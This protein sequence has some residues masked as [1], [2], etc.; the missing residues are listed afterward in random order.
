MLHKLKWKILPIL[1]FHLSLMQ[2]Y[3]SD[4]MDPPGKI[5]GGSLN[6]PIRIEVFSNFGCSACREYYLRTI[7]KVLKEYCSVDKVCVIYHDYPFKSH[8]YDREAA[9][10]AE[11][12]FRINRETMLEV[13]EA[14]YKEQAN[15]SQDGRLRD[16]IAKALPKDV[17]EKL[18]QIAKDPGID[19]IIEEQYALAMEKG[20]KST[21]TSFI[22]YSGKQQKKVE[23]NIVYVNLKNYID[24]VLE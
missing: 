1:F 19:T 24:K 22:F 15:W 4:Q 13:M 18:M 20:L 2:V 9:R 11:A 21:P 17:Y 6:S 3:S 8:K 16:A 23:Q 7:K 5:L 10:Y 12:A 14:L